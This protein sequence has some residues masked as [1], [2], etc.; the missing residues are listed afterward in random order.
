MIGADACFHRAQTLGISVSRNHASLVQIIP[1]RG[2]VFTFD[3]Q[4]VDALAASDL[5]CRHGE[6]VGG[7]GNRTQF[8]RR[9]DPAPHA[10][11]NAERAVFLDVGMLAFVDETRLRIVLIFQWPI[12]E[13][14]K[15]QGRAADVAPAG[16]FPPAFLPDRWHGF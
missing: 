6:F 5:H 7:I 4:Q 3:A 10:W 11:Y 13:Q 8:I 16:C 14:V 1:N 15:I 2:Q 9:G 12:R